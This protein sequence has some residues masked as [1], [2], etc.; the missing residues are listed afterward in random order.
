MISSSSCLA[1]SHPA[2]SLN[3]TLGEDSSSTRALVLPNLSA[4]LPPACIWR[5]TKIHS[6][7]MTMSGSHVASTESQL[8]PAAR[9]S[10]STV[11]SAFHTRSRR[12]VPSPR[13]FARNDLKGWSWLPTRIVDSFFSSPVTVCSTICRFWM[14]PL[15]IS[16]MRRVYEISARWGE[17]MLL[18]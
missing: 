11:G 18:W 9:A 7:K 15:S 12:S 6:P 5:S 3:V 16:C 17:R 13:M 14:L 2:T 4:A 1:S 10:I 8:N